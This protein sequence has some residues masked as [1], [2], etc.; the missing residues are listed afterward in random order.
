[1]AK[2]RGP[3]DPTPAPTAEDALLQKVIARARRDIDAFMEFVF[4][5]KQAKCHSEIQHHIQTE[6]R[7][8]VISHK[9]LGKTTQC[10]GNT[11]FDLGN[12]PDLRI[13]LICADDDSAK[14]RVIMV[15]DMIDRNPYL[16]RVFPNLRRH[17]SID[18]WGKGSLTVQRD[19]YSKDSSFEAAGIL[20]SGTGQRADK[21]LFDDVCNFQNTIQHPAERK[22][23][24]DAFKN[25]WIPTLGPEGRAA[26][27]AN[28]HHD[29]D[30]TAE[31]EKNAAWKWLDM[32]VRGEP[33]WSPWE[34]HWTEAALIARCEEIGS[35]EFD[36]TMRNIIRSDSERK[37]QEGWIRKFTVSPGRG[38]QRFVSW[39]YGGTGTNSD[40]TAY[41]VVDVYF[42][43]KRIRVQKVDRRKTKSFNEIIEW[44]IEVFNTWTP[45][46]VLS[47]E[48]GFMIVIGTDERIIGQY[49][50][51]KITP[52]LNKEQRV[53]QTS[54]LYEKGYVLFKD[55]E[56]EGGIQELVDFPKV[57]NDDRVDAITQAV[58]RA[59]KMIGKF[60]GPEQSSAAKP[61]VFTAHANPDRGEVGM[62]AED[63]EYS[64]TRRAGF[65]SMKW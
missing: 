62:G 4:R 65:R 8:G 49:P 55:G 5:I 17:D 57:T 25:V 31:L 38:S 12:N 44:W 50:Y 41:A 61:R 47:E 18:D 32:S 16:H 26:Y 52:V 13:K 58:I 20:T 3:G 36:R 42:E 1:M 28:R 63:G 11:L 60:F 46:L 51:E 27:I 14:D 40:Y 39:D 64:R 33:P 43:E 15:R 59:M 45:D 19:T 48:T 37:I 56:C 21:I 29:E 23:V 6:R 54:V 53:M 35:L 7:A 9:E 24:R 30:L 10:L 2:R 22:L 34:E